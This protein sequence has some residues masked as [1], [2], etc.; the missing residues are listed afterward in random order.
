MLVKTFFST[1]PR[2]LLKDE[3]SRS[4][5]ASQHVNFRKGI[6]QRDSDSLFGPLGSIGIS[7]YLILRK[8]VFS[9]S[10]TSHIF[11]LYCRFR[12][13]R[14]RTDDINWNKNTMKE[15]LTRGKRSYN[16]SVQQDKGSLMWC[17]A[18]ILRKDLGDRCI[19]KMKQ[20]KM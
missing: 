18:S 5:P 3:G 14:H 19:Q 20:D 15:S 2:N 16:F 1:A 13:C 9:D 17:N 10:L 6:L 8:S 11:L 4:I 12:L 7:L